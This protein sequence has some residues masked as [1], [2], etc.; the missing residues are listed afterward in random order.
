[1][2]IL[3]LVITLLVLFYILGAA[4]VTQKLFDFNDYCLDPHPLW[5]IPVFIFWPIAWVV[6]H[7]MLWVGDYIDEIEAWRIR[8]K[9][10][11]KE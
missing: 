6:I 5:K 7:V 3:V 11:E 1:M 4:I 10:E 8:R 9:M 2:L